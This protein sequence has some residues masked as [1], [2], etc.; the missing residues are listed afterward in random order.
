MS[1]RPRS[2]ASCSSRNGPNP[3]TRATPGR[4]PALG[5][6]QD[7]A[8]GL[9]HRG[10]DRGIDQPDSTTVQLPRHHGDLACQPDRHPQ[11][12][13]Q[14][15]QRRQPVAQV[16]RRGREVLRADLPGVE[17]DSQLGDAELGDRGGAVAAEPDQPV[18]TPRHRYGARPGL[19]VGAVAVAP[20]KDQQE[21]VDLGLASFANVGLG[22]RQQLC[23]RQLAEVPV[24][25]HSRSRTLD[26]KDALGS[27]CGLR[28]HLLAG[29][30]G[31]EALPD[32]RGREVR[33]FERDGGTGRGRR[34]VVDPVIA[35]RSTQR[36]VRPM[37]KTCSCR[38][39]SDAASGGDRAGRSSRR[40]RSPGNGRCKG[41]S[42]AVLGTSTTSCRLCRVRAT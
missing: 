38:T 36:T 27:S 33:S 25:A 29:E 30:A 3:S 18:T 23:R 34:R 22:A 10:S 6:P 4:T 37:M 7:P 31:G 41:L 5:D 28:H 32:G 12:E 35:G 9:L 17:G 26:T 20:R 21:L 14:G 42:S 8:R 1:L 19:R 24:H 2:S 15:P 40:G 11:V 16:E 13:D 39:G